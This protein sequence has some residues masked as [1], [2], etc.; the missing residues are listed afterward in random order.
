MLHLTSLVT[1]NGECNETG[2]IG[3]KM[4]STLDLPQEF[5]FWLK[6]NK[7]AGLTTTCI[8]WAAC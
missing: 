1:F 3:G 5:T 8:T 2:R 4:V 6:G 7:C